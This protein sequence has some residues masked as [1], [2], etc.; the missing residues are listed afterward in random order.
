MTAKAPAN[1]APYE[2]GGIS[3]ALAAKEEARRISLFLQNLVELGLNLRGGSRQFALGICTL[4]DHVGK[5][6]GQ[7][8]THRRVPDGQIAVAI[9]VGQVSHL[10]GRAGLQLVSRGSGSD[11]RRD[12][13]AV[14]KRP[15]LLFVR[16]LEPE[17]V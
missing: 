2:K 9:L 1:P 7:S 6:I 4:L 12:M 13:E 11:A 17:P 8:R 14:G 10:G 15:V 5:G 3:G 16:A